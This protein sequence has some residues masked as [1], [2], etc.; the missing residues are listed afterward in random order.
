MT[1]ITVSD[2]E[3]DKDITEISVRDVETITTQPPITVQGCQKEFS[4]VGDDL[5]ATANIDDV[6]DWL[7]AL[8]NR[9]VGSYI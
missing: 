5:F 4:I 7:S 6:P 1:D 9:V 3:L 8:L 2:I